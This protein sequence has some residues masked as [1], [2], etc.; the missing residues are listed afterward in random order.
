MKM[1][2][3]DARLR[4]Y[5]DSVIDNAVQDAAFVISRS[6]KDFSYG[7]KGDALAVKDLAVQ[8]FFDS[9]YYAFNVYGNPASMARVRACVP[10]LIFIG[11]DGFY[12][13]AINSYSDEDNNTVMEH[14]W[15][16]K[17]HYIGELLQDRYSVRYTLGDQVYV[18]D[19]TNSELTKGEYTDFKDK[20]P[21]FAD[22][23]NFEILRD[24][25]V[26]QSVEKEFALYIEKYNSLCHKSSFA[27]ELQFPAVDEEDWKRTLSDVGLLAFAQGFPVLHGQKYEHYALGCARVIRKAPIVGYKYAGQLYYCRTGCEFYRDTVRENTWDIIYFNAPEEAAQKGYFPC[28]YCRP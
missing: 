20:I 25:A 13:Y 16:P 14:C 6:V 21:F 18:Y 1:I 23:D 10:V 22:R 28:T 15:F 19:R 17:K 5:Y 27:L 26:R 2:K 9:L 8:T 4:A 11:E 3:E 7:R 12:L 24:S